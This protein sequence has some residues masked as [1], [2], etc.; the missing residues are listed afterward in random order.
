MYGDEVVGIGTVYQDLEL[1]QDGRLLYYMGSN[2]RDPADGTPASTYSPDG[3]R[4]VEVQSGVWSITEVCDLQGVCA[5]V[6]TTA[7]N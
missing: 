2:P 6:V 5:P 1:R 3:F 7:L 4:L